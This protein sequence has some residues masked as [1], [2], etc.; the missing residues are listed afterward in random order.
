MRAVNRESAMSIAQRGY[1][2]VELSV[3]VLVALFLLA[4]VLT[5]VQN[6][7]RAFRTQNQLAQLQDGARLAMTMMADVIQIAG[8]FPDPTT[9]TAASTLTAN[10]P[11]AAG[12]AITGTYSGAAPGDTVA[13]RYST[14]SGDG[15]LNCSGSANTTGGN[16][17][18]VN[19]FSV[20]AGQLVCSLNGR[21]YG[22]VAGVQ[23][24]SVLY[25][26]KTNFAV[27]DNNVDT[28]LRASDMTSANWG[29]VISIRVRL[30]FT[31]PLYPN[32]GQGQPPTISFERVVD[33]MGRAG[34]K[35]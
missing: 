32:G 33:V 3:A 29:N 15:I 10:A 34:L 12:Q 18:Y 16:Q 27:D 11:F 35:V 2:L 19:V 8:Y 28:Y 21:Q 26:V 1:S 14:A 6:N 13:V 23:S 20:S 7:G 25:G 9:N 24:L 17:V 5:V 30:T 22:L 4:G 31:N